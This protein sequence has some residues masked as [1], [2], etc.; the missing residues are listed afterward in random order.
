MQCEII[1]INHVLA[2]KTIKY[3]Q[4]A[5]GMLLRTY[6]KTYILIHALV[7]HD[8]NTTNTHCWGI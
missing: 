5:P 4:S 1:K 8:S 7:V 2:E 3:M 6:T